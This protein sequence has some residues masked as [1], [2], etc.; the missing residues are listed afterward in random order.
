MSSMPPTTAGLSRRSLAAD[1]TGYGRALRFVKRRSPASGA[2]L[3][4]GTLALGYILFRPVSNNL[5]LYPVFIGLGLLAAIVIWRSR[6]HLA[7]ELLCIAFL[8]AGLGLYGTL[9]GLGN[10]GLPFTLLVYFAAPMLFLL[11]AF[12]ATLQSIRWFIMIAAVATIAIATVMIT[13]VAGEAEIM[14]QIIP[15]WLE[16]ALGL[17]ATFRG[18]ASQARFYGLS[19]LAALGPLWAGSLFV[20]RDALLPHWSVRLLCAI[21]A[22]SAAFISSRNAIVLVILLAPILTLVIRALLRPRPFRRSEYSPRILA[23]GGT[24]AALA[25]IALIFIGPT[26]LSLGPVVRAFQAVSSF[27]GARGSSSAVDQSIRSDQSFHLLA[28]WTANPVFGSG[29]GARVPGYDRT[30]ERPWVLELQYHVFLYNVGLVGVVFVAALIVCV[31]IILRR[32]ARAAPQLLSSL[33]I[34]SVAAIAM[35]IANAT[36]PYLQAPGH[37]WALFLPLALAQVISRADFDSSVIHPG[38]SRFEALPLR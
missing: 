23:V 10:P 28:A 33:T 31:V 1:D 2:A 32:T 30:S 14:R 34:A 29:F 17:G 24:L 13:Y 36:N 20:R 18:S 3:M 11:C 5:V 27:F 4:A 35:V 38:T 26:L 15:A 7:N 6:P 19:S 12:A 9:I 21:A 8:I 37:F 16:D 25:S 22:T